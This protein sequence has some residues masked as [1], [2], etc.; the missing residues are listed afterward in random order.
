[1]SRSR[2][3][4]RAD[5]MWHGL[6]RPCGGAR[7]HKFV[8]WNPSQSSNEAIHVFG[9][10][11]ASAQRIGILVLRN[12]RHD[13]G[14]ILIICTQWFNPER[15]RRDINNSVPNWTGIICGFIVPNTATRPR[16]T[17][18]HSAS[19]VPRTTATHSSTDGS[20]VLELRPVGS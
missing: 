12:T 14:L 9:L 11:A 18:P 19:P 6:P 13:I 10:R 16:Q 20:R 3:R 1:M 7:D 17:V 5:R 15:S 8:D 2:S 4:N